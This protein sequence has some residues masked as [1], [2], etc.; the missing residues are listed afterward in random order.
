MQTQRFRCRFALVALAALIGPGLRIAAVQQSQSAMAYAV[1]MPQPSSHL[2]HVALRVD[3]LTGEFHDFKMPAW[4]PGYYR[5]ID[6]ARSVS[7]FRALGRDNKPLRWEKTTK[8]TW[9][10][11]TAGAPSVDISYDV[12]G[13]TR[14]S[15]QNYLDEDRA[16]IAPT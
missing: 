14:F 9:R 8:N 11:V 16:F 6:Y 13:N 15:A 2:F 1:S 3:G 10:V 12:F 5:L 4:H 7:N